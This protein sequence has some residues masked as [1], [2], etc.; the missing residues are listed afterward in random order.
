MS[1]YTSEELLN[2]CSPEVQ[3]GYNFLVNNAR[4]LGNVSGKYEPDH[5]TVFFALNRINSPIVEEYIKN[6]AGEDHPSPT[7][8]LKTY[9]HKLCYLIQLYSHFGIE[10]RNNSTIESVIET[11]KNWQNRDGRLPGEI[12]TVGRL[13]LLNMIE[14]DS[15]VTKRAESYYRE[16]W[17]NHKSAKELAIGILTLTEINHDQYHEQINKLAN[18]LSGSQRKEGYFGQLIYDPSEPEAPKFF[19]VEETSLAMIALSRVGEYKDEIKKAA[20]WLKREQRVNGQWVQNEAIHH[21]NLHHRLVSTSY[22]LMGLNTTLEGPHVSR[23]NAE[24]QVKLEKQRK[25]HIRPRFVQTYPSSI[26][27]DR[28]VEIRKQAESMIVSAENEIRICSLMI[29]MLHEKLIDKAEKGVDVRVLTRGG[30][31]KGERK[32]LKK[33]V[34]RELVKRTK[35]KVRSDHLVHSRLLIRDD[36]EL[37]VSTADLTR[38]Q[39]HDEFNA[40]IHTNDAKTTQAA[41][42][43][44]DSIWD[45]AEP[46]S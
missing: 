28:K 8:D 26:L 3:N 24:W 37:L 12:D 14:P 9:P 36:R 34:I 29:D 11:V 19:P 30:H 27:E 20:S 16:N 41:I 2:T 46:M 45:E 15:T 23:S 7:A 42:E 6:L 17:Q 39:L 4:K 21:R 33:A 40:G 35:G 13:R 18:Q 43:Y 25:N 22:A 1:N 32:K 10:Y 31:E 38:D 5:C 44:F